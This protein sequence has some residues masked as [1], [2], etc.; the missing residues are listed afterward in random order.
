MLRKIWDIGSFGKRYMVAALTYAA[1]AMFVISVTPSQP[2]VLASG[3]ECSE[4]DPCEEG[5]D[6]CDGECIDEDDLCCE[7]GSHGSP[8]TCCCCSP[9]EGEPTTLECMP[10]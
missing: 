3:T 5:L 10:E 2:E 4:E 7:D 6:C 1:L 8:D 9:E